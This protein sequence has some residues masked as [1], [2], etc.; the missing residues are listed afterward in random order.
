MKQ[1]IDYS[2]YIDRYLEGIM[3][4][5]EKIWFEKELDDNP[6]LNEELMLHK[7]VDEVIGDRELIDLEKQLDSIYEV[8]YKPLYGFSGIFRNPKVIRGA[9]SAAVVAVMIFVSVLF[10]NKPREEAME[11]STPSELFAEFYSPAE[12][13]LS[14]RAAGDVV[15]KEL[16][17]AMMLYDQKEYSRAIVLFEKILKDDAS[18]IGLNLYSGISHMELEEYTQANTSFQKIIDDKSNAFIESAEWY[19]ALC[20]MMTDEVEMASELFRKIASSHG[21]YREDAI[22]IL[23]MIN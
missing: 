9:A 18:R 19:L 7:K 14:F 20:Y 3:T 1:E 4:Q 22:R 10:L 12:M 21:Y 13:S 15:D 8:T 17:E 16:R 5:K 23:K 6:E 11:V 2:G